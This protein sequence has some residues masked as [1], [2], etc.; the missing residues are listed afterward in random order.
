MAALQSIRK[1]GGLLIAVIGLALFA[2]IA[3]EFVRSISTSSAISK[4][5]AASVFGEKIS[6]QDYQELESAVM[7]LMKEQYQTDNL[8]DQQIRTAKNQAWES[9]VQNQLIAHE[10]EE[11]GITVTDAEVERAISEGRSQ[12]LQGLLQSPRLS[13]LLSNQQTG[14]YDY[15]ALK[16]NLKQC[17]E[18]KNQ[19]G[20]Q[21]EFASRILK[22]WKYVEAQVRMELLQQKYMCLAFGSQIGSPAM[23]QEIADKYNTQVSLA[24]AELPAASIEDKEAKAT[25]KDIEELYN[26]YKDMFVLSQESRDI[27]YI[28]FQVVASAADR[29]ELNGKM[30]NAHK[31][32]VEG[33]DVTAA[34]AGLNSR[35]GFADLYV[36]KSTYPYDVQSRLDSLSVGAVSP[37]YYNASD[38]TLNVIKYIGQESRPDSVAVRGI[39]VMG[40]DEKDVAARAD[41]ILNALNAGANYKDIATKYG[42]PADTMIQHIPSMLP[43]NYEM[44][45]SN[46]DE[47]SRSLINTLT[48]K[49]V[50]YHKIELGGMTQILQICERKS[51]QPK[52][53][54]AVIKVPVDYSTATY[55]EKVNDFNRFI[56]QNKTI[57]DIEKNAAKAGYVVNEVNN[58]A[59]GSGSIN[60]ISGTENA[61]RWIF[62]EADEESISPLYEAVGAGRDHLLLVAVTAVNDG[63]Y[64][65]ATNKSVV[66]MLTPLADAKVKAEA[67]Y[68][69]LNGVKTIAEA[70]KKGAQVDSLTNVSLAQIS[71]D[72]VVAGA[73][74]RLKAG[75]TTTVKGLSG[76]YTVQVISKGKS[77]DKFDAEQAKS[78]AA[79]MDRQR[80]S[81]GMQ[82][83]LFRNA[84]IE[85][86]RYRF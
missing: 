36:S 83:V 80:L 32:L 10:A 59:T 50:G 33:E 78:Q 63:K 72:C 41:S 61:I 81:Q 45:S 35:T 11:L 13:G 44:L 79:Y 31:M 8:N 16:E 6:A 84:K 14:Q 1:R 75:E 2:F 40:K 21:M 4:Q 74:A 57:A 20:E 53:N 29:Q 22:I 7:E 69:K 85:D 71:K 86:N 5:Q 39:A 37:V 25:E 24:V 47:D 60:G 27:K 55:N 15:N 56:S 49:G 46:I 68:K 30:E 77:A 28:D 82:A 76:A 38:N 73:A 51:F 19:G 23:A 34:M 9:Y 58:F 12:A 48:T 65:P 62:D 3:E 70:Q 18:L 17:E 43:N 67:A 42:Q 66:E 26:E 54:V 52:Y 64:L